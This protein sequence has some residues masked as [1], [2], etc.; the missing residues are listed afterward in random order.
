MT[1]KV[2]CLDVKTWEE[3]DILNN[4]KDLRIVNPIIEGILDNLN[5][6]KRWVHVL[7]VY[8]EEEGDTGHITVDRLQFKEVLEENL[9]TYVNYEM[10]DKCIKIR[11]TIK[12]LENK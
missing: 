1:E 5:T 8:I 6:K 3:F 4:N 7:D 9:E 2:K 11:D 10:Y 12:E